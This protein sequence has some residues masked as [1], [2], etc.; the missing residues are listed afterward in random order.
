VGGG[1]LG[2]GDA[3]GETDGLSEL[4]GLTDGETDEETE[5]EGLT[6]GE[7]ELLGLTDGETDGL[8]E[9]DG[10]TDEDGETEAEGLTEGETDD[11]GDAEEIGSRSATRTNTG[12]VF[13]HAV[14]VHVSAVSV[15]IRV[16][17]CKA[18]LTSP[19]APVRVSC[20]SV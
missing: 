14:D 16:T 1:T 10:L 11:D 12:S 9:A 6:E 19:V 8:T 4:L 13:V 5:A 20:R 3:D 18:I 7:T 15:A 17:T 2:L